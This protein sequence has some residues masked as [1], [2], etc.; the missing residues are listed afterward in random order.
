MMA[1]F[2]TYILM[3]A[4][5]FPQDRPTWG[6]KPVED[7]IWPEWKI[8]FKPLQDALER[9]SIAAT[10]QPDIFGTAAS[11]QW[12][13]GIIPGT[14]ISNDL[15]GG[16]QSL[17]E[18][19]DNQ[20]DALKLAATNSNSALEQLAAATTTQY[21]MIQTSLNNLEAATPTNTTPPAPKPAPKNV[22][23]LPLTNIRV[24][25]NKI[26]L[27][28]GAYKNK[29]LVGEFCSTHGQAVGAGQNSVDCAG[30]R[31]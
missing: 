11:A 25:E 24:L 6:G 8:F 9:K 31:N 15:G 16:G 29:W 12:Y 4:S 27:L 14:P 2:A 18:K 28:Q 10:G 5:S 1:V 19:L 13:H 22:P 3:K 26:K 7:Q 20:F 30:K 17:I 21:A 23:P